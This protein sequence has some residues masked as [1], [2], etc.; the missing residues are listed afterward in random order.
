MKRGAA[1]IVALAAAGALAVAVPALSDP[2][3]PTAWDGT[4]PFRC[5]LQQA[6][7]GAVGPHP[8]ADPYCI[9]FDKRRQNITELGVVQF[10]SEEPARTAAAVP[11]CFY[12]QSDHWRGSIVQDDATTK[13]YEWD[14]HYF[15]DKAT[16]DG[17]VW[18]TNFNINGHTFDPTTIPGFPPDWARFF[19]PGTGGAIT[20]N[21]IPTDPTCVAKAAQHP[22]IYASGAPGV[23]RPAGGCPAPDGDVTERAMGPVALG[24]P[25]QRVRTVLGA[26]SLVKRG[27]MHYCLFGGGTELVGEPGD[28][29]G[30][31]GSDP[32][33]PVV[34]LYTTSSAYR[35]GGV[36]T[37]AS[38]RAV[39]AAFPKARLRFVKG[40]TRVYDALGR[41]GVLVG[42]LRRRVRFV[43]VYDARHVRSAHA[44][45]EWLRRA[46]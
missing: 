36:G 12:F 19:G 28:R 15:F 13:T 33:A 41:P 17:G 20:H 18:V 43:A 16:G 21:D 7:F 44:L 8:D 39:R 34:F 11:K 24:D 40:S 9:E 23:A 31:R 46:R 37:G 3:P 45:R 27:W 22:D 26:P 38:A 1:A 42:V 6:G 10:L 5:E 32:A 25:D 30:E 35:V 4:N 14:G 2:A 29:S